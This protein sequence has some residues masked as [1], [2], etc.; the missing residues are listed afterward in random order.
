M[1]AISPG[2]RPFELVDADDVEPEP[3][4]PPPPLPLPPPD[5]DP[6]VPGFVPAPE[7]LGTGLEPAPELALVPD[8]P[9]PLVLV[10]TTPPVTPLEPDEA[11]PEPARAA[12][13]V[14]E[15]LGPDDVE[16]ETPPEDDCVTTPDTEML[17]A[18]LVVAAPVAPEDI[19]PV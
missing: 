3:E 14:P 11:V 16:A 2:E 5:P 18:P 17:P 6:E 9:L 7:V 1:A 12:V 15:D 10:G 19:E 4:P 13:A 8:V